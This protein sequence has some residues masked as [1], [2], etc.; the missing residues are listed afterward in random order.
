MDLVLNNHDDKPELYTS[1]MRTYTTTADLQISKGLEF[2]HPLSNSTRLESLK[3][4][5]E[6]FRRF[7]NIETTLTNQRK[8]SQMTTSNRSR[9][10]S[11]TKTNDLLL[12]TT[13]S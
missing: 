9:Y 8:H 7:A 2:S 4:I 13:Q 10:N 1:K 11:T 6:A 12:N 5:N 3:L